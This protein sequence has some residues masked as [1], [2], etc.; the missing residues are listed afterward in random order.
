MALRLAGIQ[1]Y[2]L[3]DN[4]MAVFN[5]LSAQNTNVRIGMNL[6]FGKKNKSIDDIH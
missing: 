2:A 6:A 5:P 3:T 1:L 4:V